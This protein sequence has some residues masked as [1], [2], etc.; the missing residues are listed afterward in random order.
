MNQLER[1]HVL[2]LSKESIM[3]KSEKGFFRLQLALALFLSILVCCESNKSD[4]SPYMSKEKFDRPTE[5]PL[6]KY[7]GILR[8]IK[9]QIGSDTMPFIFDTGGGVTLITPEIADK[10]NCTPFG[11]ITG[12]RSTGERIDLQRCGEVEFNIKGIPLQFEAA[13]FDLMSLL[14]KDW[15]KVGGIFSLDTFRNHAITLDLSRNRLIIET[16]DSL[17]DRI[18]TMKPVNIRI[19][20]Q[21][22]G[23][24]LDIFVEIEAN[25]GSLWLELDTGNMGEVLLAPHA[26]EQ[27]GLPVPTSDKKTIGLDSD[28]F[29]T[30]LNI[31]GLGPLNV[32]ARK[33]EL[34][35]DG[36]LNASTIEK[37][38]LTMDLT[39][40]I[41][42][43]TLS[44]YEKKL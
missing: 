31:V 4:V 9:A 25:R 23:W 19:N 30:T 11:R 36:I 27:L 6:H 1:S 34:I 24:S 8:T 10:I 18:T 33:Q 12:F 17:E 32:M 42:W 29:K 3:L 15:P 43:A 21:A 35:Y 5:I 16:K 7:V 22:G 2:N 14:P 13:V 40:E 28:V 41:M 38:I 20:H 26:I 37:L 39:N 44:E